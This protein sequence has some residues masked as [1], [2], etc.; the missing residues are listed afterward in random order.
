M[1]KSKTYDWN[2]IRKEFQSSS[3][4]YTAFAKEKGIAKST[5]Y[6]HVRDIVTFKNLQKEQILADENDDETVDFIPV[7]VIEAE[8]KNAASDVTFIKTSNKQEIVSQ[9][10]SVLQNSIEIKLKDFSIELNEGFNKALLKDALEVL[11]EL[12]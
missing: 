5:L 12:C 8:A 6:A 1:D 11:A 10:S 3:L 9:P 2:K 7:E 4:C